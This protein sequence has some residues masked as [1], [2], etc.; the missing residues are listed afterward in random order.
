MSFE[1]DARCYYC[2]D[3]INTMSGNPVDGSVALCHDDAP[4]VAKS[5]HI[6]CVQAR[7]TYLEQILAVAS[8]IIN[9]IGGK[10]ALANPDAWERNNKD[11]DCAL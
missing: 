9:N 11:W 3:P 5:H 10:P 8:H 4:G 2:G 6:G 1:H 7:L